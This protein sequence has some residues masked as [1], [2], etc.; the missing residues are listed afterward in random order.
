MPRTDLDDETLRPARR[1]ASLAG[2]LGTLLIIAAIL[3]VA[4]AV[5]IRTRGASELVG[6]YLRDR[7]GLNLAV[8]KC[9]FVLP[10]ELVV[11]D[12]R[13]REPAEAARGGLV[14]REVRVGWAWGG[15]QSLSVRGADLRLVK[16]AEGWQPEPLAGVGRLT[17]VRE[18]QA[19][20]AAW[21]GLTLD[22]RDSTVTWCEATQTLGR[23]EGLTFLSSP[24]RG[25]G[26]DFRY[27]EL[28]GGT[29]LREGGITGTAVRR[30]W[31][32]AEENAY[33]ELEYRGFWDGDGPGV[34]DWWTV[35]VAGSSLAGGS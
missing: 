17:D 18:T 7:T 31:I 6:D 27:Y 8:G 32:G 24:L 21:P 9:R 34:K 13:L 23:V 22:I 5:A 2:C 35:P 4:A 28:R 11:E 30:R 20:F 1:S 33:L 15:A 10:C 26:R 12:L 16:T 3:L 29:V 19:L 14:A 25:A